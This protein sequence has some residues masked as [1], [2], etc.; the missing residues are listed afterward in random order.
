VGEIKA[1]GINLGTP[2][3]VLGDGFLE[4]VGR[5]SETHKFT[6]A[7]AAQIFISANPFCGF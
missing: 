3:Q 2:C 6:G 4:K 1:R 5:A 7:F